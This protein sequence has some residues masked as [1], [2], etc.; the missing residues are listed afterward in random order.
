LLK[1][2][3][4]KQQ[5]CCQEL[6]HFDISFRNVL[7]ELECVCREADDKFDDYIDSIYLIE[8]EIKDTTDTVRFASYLGPPL[9]N[10]CVTYDHNRITNY[11]VELDILGQCFKN[12][13]AVA[14]KKE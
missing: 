2:T 7:L 1:N 14:I 6:H 13:T 3:S 12:L 11:G 10:S 9:R 4:T 5:I 8:L